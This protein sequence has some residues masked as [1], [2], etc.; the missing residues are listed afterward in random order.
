MKKNL[1]KDFTVSVI[2]PNYN[3]FELLEKNLPKVISAF[4]NTKN[5]ITQ[6]III[7]DGSTDNSI[8]LIK[9]KF[10]EVTLVRHKIN[11]GFIASVNTGARTASG[12]LLALLNNDVA[13]SENF[14]ESVNL[15]FENPKVFAVSLH[16][17]GYAWAKGY[18]KDGFIVHA[19]GRETDQVRE[20]FWVSGGTGVFR[21]EYWMKLGG[22]D[23]KLLSPFYWEDVDISYRAMKRGWV[24]LWDPEAKVVHEHEST[25]KNIDKVYRTRIQER[26]QLIFIWKNLTSGNLIKKHIL[27]LVSRLSGHPKYFIIVAMALGKIRLILKARRRELKES[28]VSDEAIL[29]KF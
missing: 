22:M 29:G 5:K 18:F 14:L 12:E 27:G 19:S 6:I 21:R 2:I 17:K 11:R 24:N 15:V 26:N 16:E 7:D 9:E 28:K 8:K 4:H 1:S 20:T 3:G 13:P 10:K 23:E 25:V